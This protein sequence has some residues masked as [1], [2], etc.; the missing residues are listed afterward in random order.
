MKD[1]NGAELQVGD[2]VVINAIKMNIEQ[3]HL[4]NILLKQKKQISVK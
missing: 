4:E 3:K 2:L 1:I